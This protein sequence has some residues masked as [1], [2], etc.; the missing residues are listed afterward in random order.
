MNVP[1]DGI[2]ASC[3][4]DC[5]TVGIGYLGVP[6]VA[7]FH[8]RSGIRELGDSSESECGDDSRKLH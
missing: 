5:V 6:H 4:P 1:S 2:R 7:G 3:I 8:V